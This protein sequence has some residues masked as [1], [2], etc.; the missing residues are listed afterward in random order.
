MDKVGLPSASWE[1]RMPRL[2]GAEVFRRLR[3]IRADVPIL[4][5]S[6]YAE[7]DVLERFRQGPMIDRYEDLYRRVLSP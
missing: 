3:R 4:L 6:G 1:R 2:D 7:G 5:S